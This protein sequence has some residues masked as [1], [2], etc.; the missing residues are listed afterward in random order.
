M[1]SLWVHPRRFL[2]RRRPY[3]PASTFSALFS[4]TFSGE[5]APDESTRR[6][7]AP[8]PPPAP[9]TATTFGSPNIPLHQLY[10][11]LQADDDRAYTST[12]AI[13]ARDFWR[14]HTRSH[15]KLLAGTHS[16]LH[17]FQEGGWQWFGR[18]G[19]LQSQLRHAVR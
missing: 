3:Y 19:I 2:R 14:F 6:A 15:D 17:Q 1:T 8:P 12:E 16:K 13:A 9:T 5:P 4:S 11:R 10:R 18:G 7:P